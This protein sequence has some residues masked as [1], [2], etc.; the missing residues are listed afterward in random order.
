[1]KRIRGMFKKIERYDDIFKSKQF[2]QD[3]I[4]FNVMVSIVEDVDR[5]PNPKIFSNSNN[6]II[7]NSDSEHPIITWT[8]DDFNDYEMLFSFI[9]KEFGDNNPFKIMSKMGFY[10]FLKDKDKIDNSDIKI[11]GAYDCIKLNDIKYIGNA[12]NATKEELPVVAKLHTLFG[13]ET[14]EDK[15]ATIENSMLEVEKL[16][17]NPLF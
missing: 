7:V 16:I 5:Y 8:T 11:L 9:N 12:Q 13:Q 3:A 10:N 14:G 2:S 1:M 17:D 15:N 6:C 4:A